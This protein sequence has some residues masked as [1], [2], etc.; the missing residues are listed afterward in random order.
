MFR[1]GIA[2]V[3]LLAAAGG[4]MAESPAECG[5]YLVNTI[6]DCGNCH[7]K[8]SDL[9]DIIAYLRMVPPLQ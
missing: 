7:T 4:A 9:A 5:G 8:A 1:I 3:L 6:M 2:C